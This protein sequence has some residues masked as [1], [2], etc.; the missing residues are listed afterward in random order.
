MKHLFGHFP[1][2]FFPLCVNIISPLFPPSLKSS[3]FYINVVRPFCLW[4]RQ[5]GQAGSSRGPGQLHHLWPSLSAYLWT[6][7]RFLLHHTTLSSVK[8]HPLRA[9][10]EE[11][12]LRKTLYCVAQINVP[13]LCSWQW[14]FKWQMVSTRV[15]SSDSW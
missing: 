10:T 4:Q 6:L 1:S 8:C 11:T 13:P 9:S 3:Y 14:H 15:S 5:T 2:Q 12:K 7:D